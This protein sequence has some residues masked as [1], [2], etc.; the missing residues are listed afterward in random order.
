VE[1]HWIDRCVVVHW[2]DDFLPRPLVKEV[3][4]VTVGIRDEYQ[5]VE[6]TISLCKMSELKRTNL[7]V[8]EMAKKVYEGSL[9]KYPFESVSW[10]ESKEKVL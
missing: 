8:H 1:D 9:C 6:M 3:L 5:V 10:P 2:A 7:T 4:I